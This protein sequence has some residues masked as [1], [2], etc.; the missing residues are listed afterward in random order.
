MNDKLSIAIKIVMANTQVAMYQAQSYHWNCTGC[1]FVGCHKFFKDIY[2]ELFEAIDE[3][4]EQIRILG[5]Q[6]P[7]S[8]PNLLIYSTLKNDSEIPQSYEE[9]ITQ[10]KESNQGIIDS[11]HKVIK[12]IK[13]IDSS[14][15][16]CYEDVLDLIVQR[17][18]IH[19]KTHWMLSSLLTKSKK[20]S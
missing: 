15:T 8:I 5:D 17:L 6:T 7:Y 20:E 1:H 2:D 4:A 3:I 18:K 14:D 16:E 12:L 9:M 19:K 11:I 13:E 10:Y